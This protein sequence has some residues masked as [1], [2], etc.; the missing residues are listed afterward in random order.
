MAASNGHEPLLVACKEQQQYIQESYTK[1]D[2]THLL[3]RLPKHA[4]SEL[5]LPKE[6]KHLTP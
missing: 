4:L 6:W 1:V 3:C 5:L 2:S